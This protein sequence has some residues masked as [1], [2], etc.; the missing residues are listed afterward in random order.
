MPLS[1][2]TWIFCLGSIFDARL[3][4][5]DDFYTGILSNEWC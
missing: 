1:L 4:D 5:L 3:E 2:G